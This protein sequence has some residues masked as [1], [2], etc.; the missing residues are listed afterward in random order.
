MLFTLTRAMLK[1]LTPRKVLFDVCVFCLSLC[2]NYFSGFDYVCMGR[3]WVLI[4]S[5]VCICCGRVPL[6]TT[7][8]HPSA[9]SMF[10]GSFKHM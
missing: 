8:G 4:S 5:I 6:A 2:M 3:W 7:N 9:V 10:N 1:R